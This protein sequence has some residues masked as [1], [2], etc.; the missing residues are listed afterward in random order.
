M[1]DQDVAP[2]PALPS[3]MFEGEGNEGGAPRLTTFG[4]DESRVQGCLTIESENPPARAPH[5]G[6]IPE[7]ARSAVIRNP[8]ASSV[9]ASGFRVRAIRVED[10]RERAHGAAPE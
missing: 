6:V 7:T 3:L 2:K 9:C 5:T 1:P 10:A 4:A 8:E